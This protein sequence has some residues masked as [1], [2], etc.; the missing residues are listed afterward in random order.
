[1][2]GAFASVDDL[3]A[4]LRDDRGGD[5]V[6]GHAHALQ[7]IALLARARPD[8]LELQ[9]AGLVHDVASS[10]EQRPPGD[11][12]VE[13]ARLV[14]PLL[15]ARVAALVAGHV[16]AKRWLVTT[17]A[18]YRARL[19]DNSRATL[20]DQGDALDDAELA[21]F[22]AS[23]GFADCVLLRRCDDAAKRPGLVVPAL[24]R[25][26]PVVDRVA[27]FAR[28]PHPGYDERHRP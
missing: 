26:R 10:L 1:M 22:A 11:H 6:T 17:D 3:F 9:V 12:A 7:C 24:D 16:V 4:V 14:R 2:S 15:G 27:E 13:G 8:D 28:S 20:A 5:V 21:A 18:S 19:S 25:W 23:P